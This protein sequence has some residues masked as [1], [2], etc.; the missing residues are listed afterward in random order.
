MTTHRNRQLVMVTGL[1]FG[2]AAGI[3]GSVNAV[4][5]VALVGEAGE[6]AIAYFVLLTIAVLACGSGVITA[7][8]ST[9]TPMGLWVGLFLGLICGVG[10][11]I[12]KTRGMGWHRS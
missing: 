2:L 3:V 6:K 4:T 7:H 11:L 5:S 1:L 10:G 9:R 8:I 12:S